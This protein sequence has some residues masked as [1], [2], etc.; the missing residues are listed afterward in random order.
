MLAD[1]KHFPPHDAVAVSS[2]EK[3]IITGGADSLLVRWRD[4]TEAVRAK[5][6][7]EQEEL[8]LQQQQLSNLV[9]SKQL[10]KAL[11]LALKL[12]HPHRV[13]TIVQGNDHGFS[14][15]LIEII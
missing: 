13:L 3:I 8:A 12:K 15:S 5:R 1:F 7:A 4:T 6:I 10:L 14:F 11:S 2:D 9:M